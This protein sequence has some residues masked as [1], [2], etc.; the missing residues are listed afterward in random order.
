MIKTKK[1]IL[2]LTAMVFIAC[3]QVEPPK[4]YGPTPTDNHMNWHEMEYYGLVCY[5]LNTYT[6][7][8]WGYGDVDSRVF[9]PSNLNTDQ[10]ARVAKEAGMKGLILVAK[11][12]D[13]FCL[14]PSKTTQYTIAAT[15]WKDGKGDVLRD[16]ANSC[17]KFGLKLGIYISPWD[18]NHAQYGYPGYVEA[19]HQQWREALEYSDDIWEVWFDGANGGTGYYGGAREKRTIK[20]GYYNFPEIFKLIKNKQ[21]NAIIFGY[22]EDVTTDV[23]RW[24]GTEQGSGSETNWCRFDDPTTKDLELK[25]R[26]VKDG[27]YWMPVEGNTTI[28]YPKKWYYNENSKPRTLKNFVDLYYT[29][30]GQNATFL[31]GL[32]IGPDGQIPERDVKAMIA[33]K[34]QMDKELSVNLAQ[35]VKITGGNSR[36]RKFNPQNAVDGQTTSYWATDDS[37]KT[38]SLVLDFYQETSFNRL[39]LQEYIRLGQRIHRFVLEVEEDSDWKKIASGTT[40]GYKRIVRFADVKASKVRITLETDAPCLTLSNIE[41]YHAP[42]LLPEPEILSDINGDIDINTPKNL[43]VFYSIGKSNTSYQQYE[44]SFKLPNGGTVNA[45]TLDSITGHKSDII[46]KEFGIAKRK[47]NLH[48]IDSEQKTP[49]THVIDANPLT[50]L[51]TNTSNYISIDLGEIMSITGFGYLPPGLGSEGIIFEYEFY[52]SK[53]EIYNEEPVSKGEFSNIENNPIRQIVKFDKPIECRFVKLVSKSSVSNSNI[54]AVSEIDI[55]TE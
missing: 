5:G 46:S 29:T 27:K 2:F 15:P 51:S 18:R 55:F 34:K 38:A 4:P 45:Y 12:H 32:S 23:V 24:G 37:V 25:K 41:I 40:I 10:W 21:P 17:E 53:D 11:H 3:Q 13:G 42:P 43:F 22:V 28:L 47:W 16:L 6:G 54:M 31:L 48:L 1:T 7:Q 49:N 52:A 9:N 26:G 50:I 14:W 30:I 33:Q 19:F 8:E 39:L 35:N 36:G 20:K 44:G